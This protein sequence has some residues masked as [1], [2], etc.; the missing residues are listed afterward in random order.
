MELGLLIDNLNVPATGDTKFD[1]RSPTTG[2][3]ATKAAAAKQDDVDA[4]VEA[5]DKAFPSWSA[6]GPS[7]RRKILNDCADALD[8]RDHCAC[9]P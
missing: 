7:L 3:V 2:K 9:L 8:A 5:A 4:A 1:R 6:M